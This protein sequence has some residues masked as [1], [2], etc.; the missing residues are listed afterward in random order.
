MGLS[1]RRFTN[2]FKPDALQRLEMG[3]SARA[4]EVN[5]NVL[6]GWRREFWKGPGDVFPGLAKRRWEEG[7]VGMGASP[8]PSMISM[9]RVSRTA[10]IESPHV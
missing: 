2:E 8:E 7:R 5:P 9:P 4:F 1:R 10:A 6:D 3:V